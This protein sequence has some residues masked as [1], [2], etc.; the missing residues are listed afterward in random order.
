MGSINVVLHQV[1]SILV[2]CNCSASF[3]IAGA[4]VGASAGD[5]GGG[6]IGFDFCHDSGEVVGSEQVLL[7][8]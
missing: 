7:E 6:S 1:S 3:K 8:D 2:K 5:G 4:G